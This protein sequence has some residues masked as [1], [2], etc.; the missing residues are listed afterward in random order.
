M[1]SSDNSSKVLRLTFEKGLFSYD[2]DKQLVLEKTCG[3]ITQ[4][5]L[6]QSQKIEKD[7]KI[8]ALGS[9]TKILIIQMEPKISKIFTLAKPESILER[10]P[11]SIVWTEG[12]FHADGEETAILLLISWGNHYFLVNLRPEEILTRGMGEIIYKAQMVAHLMIKDYIRFSM[13]LSNRVFFSLLEND[14]GVLMNLEDFDEIPEKTPIL[15]NNLDEILKSLNHMISN[16]YLDFEFNEK[17]AFHSLVKDRDN[18]ARSCYSQSFAGNSKNSLFLLQDEQ[19]SVFSL[20]TW[21]KYVNSM[22]NTG[23]RFAALASLIRIYKGE[24]K[25]VAGITE[26]LKNKRLELMREYAE[27]MAQDYLILSLKKAENKEEKTMRKLILTVS[28]FLIEIED[29]E[30]LFTEIQ[31][32]LIECQLGEQFL[33]SLESFILK[34][35]IRY[36]LIIF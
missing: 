1:L 25:Y 23:D 22:I 13:F 5:E 2:C 6:L 11:A 12:L 19:V 36:F 28:E 34:G 30:F 17:L 33:E 29:S 27:M 31:K 4:I 10:N 15:E 8:L 16:E 18:M 20:F 3:Q 7:H 9:L 32:I 14:R 35:K 24:E 26:V 21:Q